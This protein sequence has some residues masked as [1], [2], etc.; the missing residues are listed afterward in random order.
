[1]AEVDFQIMDLRHML[2]MRSPHTFWRKLLREIH[3]SKNATWHIKL[4]V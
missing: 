2:Q 1:M 4:D 3:F